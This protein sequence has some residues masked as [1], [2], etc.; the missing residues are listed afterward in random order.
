MKFI[1][2]EEFLK[3]DKEVQKVFNE[4]W[5][6]KECDIYFDFAD[7]TAKCI[8]YLGNS[9]KLYKSYNNDRSFRECMRPLFTETLLREFIED[10]T[11][12]KLRI[13]ELDGSNYNIVGEHKVFTNM[14]SD[15][16]QAYWKVA[17]EVATMVINN[18]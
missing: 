2:A 10:N 14:D 9:T 5:Q 8:Y 12:G 11:G 7:I 1:S 6:P 18:E 17:L 3:Q 13:I 16:L 15:L 4:W